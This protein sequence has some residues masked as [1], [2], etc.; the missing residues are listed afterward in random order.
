MSLKS[1]EVY[2][3]V[4]RNYWS[5]ALG[6]I[7][8]PSCVPRFSLYEQSVLKLHL[9]HDG[10]TEVTD[11]TDGNIFVFIAYDYNGEP[12]IASDTTKINS[13]EALT[14]WVEVPESEG[15]TFVEGANTEKGRFA[16]LINCA[17]TE[18]R[19]A[20]TGND[21]CYFK[22]EF[23]VVSVATIISVLRER[24]YF[25]N[26]KASTD[27]LQEI[28][29]GN[30]LTSGEFVIPTGSAFIILTES[31]D[32]YTLS[33]VLVEAPDNAEEVYSVANV[34]I[35]DGAFKVW[36]NATVQEDSHKVIY[37]LVKKGN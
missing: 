1:L 31:A 18:L 33:S 22:T 35:G 23:T 12:V 25:D 21:N 26:V 14:Y 32:D 37:T 5:D 27:V 3:N 36:F 9:I 11:Y 28:V 30:P 15:V 19:D 20:L 16:V 6:N 10:G 8:V 13:V 24:C 2:F 34:S 17:T 7:S 29:F 4:D